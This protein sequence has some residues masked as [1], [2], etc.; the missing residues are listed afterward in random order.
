MVE[1]KGLL[2]GNVGESQNQSENDLNALNAVEQ[3]WESSVGSN[4]NKLDAFTK[5]VSRQAITK[6]MARYEI[7]QQQLE[8]NGSIVELGVHRGASLMAWAQ[9]SAILEPVNYL[10]KII[11]FDTFEGFP[12]LSEKDTTGTSEHLEVGGFKSEENAMEDLEQAIQLYNSTRYLNH[13]P[14][15]ELVKGDISVTLPD[16]L[17]KNQHLVVSLLHLDAD[18]YEP[19]KVALE[20]LIPRMPKGAIIAFDELNMSLFPGETLAAMETLGIPN[21]RLKRFPFATSLSYAIIE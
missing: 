17:E 11:G 16:Y 2:R 21:L 20:L 1:K 8:V 12:S 14:K 4:L 3:Y 13:I 6:L 10:R 9:F 7:F 5:Y 15:V 18:L 19:T